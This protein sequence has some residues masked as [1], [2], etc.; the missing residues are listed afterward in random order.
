MAGRLAG[1]V[2]FTM[3]TANNESTPQRKTKDAMNTAIDDLK[4]LVRDAEEV[5]ANAGDAAEDQVSDLQERMRHALE[6]SRARL[7]SAQAA[8]RE[9]LD[10]YDDYVRTHPYQSIGAAVAIGALLGIL[11]GRRGS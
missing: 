2:F 3:P 11:L 10:Q 9:Q 5:L 1:N 4:T 8:A 7:R 6:D